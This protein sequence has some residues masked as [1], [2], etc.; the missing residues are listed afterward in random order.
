MI[1]IKLDRNTKVY[2]PSESVE[3]TVVWH[4]ESPNQTAVVSLTWSTVGKG[5][6]STG[7]ARQERVSMTASNGQQ[8]L[9]LELPRGPLSCVG[10]LITIQWYVKAELAVSKTVV[11]EP[12]FLS[13][14][15]GPIQLSSL[16][17]CDDKYAFVK[18][19]S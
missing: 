16:P 9:R 2:S 6:T 18:N 1:E 11:E 13:Y 17:I 7:L 15:L 10:K 14:D 8:T 3:V 5:T 12:L 4:D 19:V